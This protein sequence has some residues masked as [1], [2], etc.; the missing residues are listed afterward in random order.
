MLWL[1]I[2]LVA[3]VANALVFVVDKSLLGSRNSVGQPL[4][5]AFYSAL[6]AG[7]A[8]VLL[9]FQYTPL[10]QFVALWSLLAGGAHLVA[11]WLLFSAMKAGEPSRVIPTAGSAVP[12]FTLLFAPAVL[13]EALTVQQMVAVILLIV[14][15][16]LLAVRLGSW[17][18][19]FFPA[20][21]TSV[22]AGAFFALHFTAM[23]FVYA[24]TDVFLPVFGYSRLVEALLAL[25]VLGPLVLIQQHVPARPAY[26]SL[27]VVPAV[28]VGNKVL[29]A[30]AF[31][32]QNYAI[33]LG[34]VTIVNAL[35]GVQYLFLLAL[36][37]AISRW[38]PRLFQEELHRVALV[39]KVVGIVWV[40]AGLALL[41]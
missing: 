19:V 14:G 20:V 34:S 5:Y 40:G 29:A 33:S 12:L 38:K 27:L 24:S 18:T 31:V 13:G 4:V 41:V 15:G 22:M 35:Q 36:A 10:T 9:L 2:A 6:L 1:S 25:V 17:H 16:G 8:G 37:V 26:A 3:H 32:L 23:K 11:L 30:G 7:A 21:G 39:Q 28:F